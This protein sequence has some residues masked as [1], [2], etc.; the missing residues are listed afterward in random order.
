[1]QDI[2]LLGF[3]GHCRSIIDSIENSNIYSI[4]GILD[5]EEKMGEIYKNYKVIGTDED[6]QKF[7]NKGIKNIFICIGFMGNN[8]IRNIL[9]QKVKKIGFEVVNIIDKTAILA[10]NIKLGEGIFIGKRAILNSNVMIDNMAIINTGAIIE[11]DSYVGEY[12]HVSI[13]SILCGSVNIGESVFIG[14]NS[15]IINNINIEKNTII[16]AGSVV[17]KDVFKNSKCYGVVK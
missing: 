2:L 6:L 13:A 4:Y 3:G 5:K 7:Y 17:V 15:T 16:G 11:H 12:S 9:Y 14:A 1:M 8:N 10:N